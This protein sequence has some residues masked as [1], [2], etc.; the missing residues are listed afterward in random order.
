MEWDEKNAHGRLFRNRCPKHY[1]PT[2]ALDPDRV[3]VSNTVNLSV[4]R[5]DVHAGFGVGFIQDGVTRHRTA[6]PMLE[7]TSSGEDERILVIG[8]FHNMDI[9]QR[10]ELAASTWKGIF[11]ESWRTGM[12]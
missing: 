5:V 1:F 3:T 10:D 11:E 6:V 9:I 8:F 4:S 7:H 2:P 12:G